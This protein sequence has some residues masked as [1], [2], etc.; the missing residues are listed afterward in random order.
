MGKNA[1]VIVM[2]LWNGE[3]EEGREGRAGEE[4]TAEERS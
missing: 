1:L 2:I 4:V 3:G